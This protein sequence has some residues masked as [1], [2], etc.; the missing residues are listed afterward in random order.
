MGRPFTRSIIRKILNSKRRE[1]RKIST[2]YDKTNSISTTVNVSKTEI[3][4]LPTADTV[5]ICHRK[6]ITDDITD[7]ELFQKINTF[8]LQLDFIANHIESWLASEF[9]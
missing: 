1:R 6:V 4:T 2:F 5:S 8:I 3:V 9:V 7:D